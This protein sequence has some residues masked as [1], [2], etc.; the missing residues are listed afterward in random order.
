MQ[1]KRDQFGELKKGL[2]MTLI[3]TAQSRKI[4]NIN[5][6]LCG[7]VTNKTMNRTFPMDQTFLHTCVQLL[8]S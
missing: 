8:T 4:Y 7:E 5:I 2:K 1:V 3:K 6:F